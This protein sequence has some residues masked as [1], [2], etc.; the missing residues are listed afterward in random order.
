MKPGYEQE[1]ENYLD[2]VEY[3][4]A[5]QFMQ[6]QFTTTIC[7]IGMTVKYCQSESL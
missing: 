3:V 6:L 1:T 7:F 5:G 2:V 4:Y